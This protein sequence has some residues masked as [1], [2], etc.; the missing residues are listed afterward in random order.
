MV[1]TV[2]YNLSEIEM[3][4]SAGSGERSRAAEMFVVKL[5][6]KL[7]HLLE[8]ENIGLPIT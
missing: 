5:F 4:H 3:C 2:S 7:S 6:Q 8:A 1:I